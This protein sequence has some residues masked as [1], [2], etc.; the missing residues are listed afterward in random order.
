MKEYMSEF[1]MGVLICEWA[2]HKECTN[3]QNVIINDWT[4]HSPG[5]AEIQQTM[6]EIRPAKFGDKSCTLQRDPL[7]VKPDRP[8]TMLIPNRV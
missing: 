3:Q 1:S 6:P 7:V 5:I 4:D 8:S 2:N